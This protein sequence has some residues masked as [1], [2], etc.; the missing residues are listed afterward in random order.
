LGETRKAHSLSGT[1]ETIVVSPDGKVLAVW[2]GA[3]T[4]KYQAEIE[5]Y[6]QIHLRGLRDL[7]TPSAPIP[8]HSQSTK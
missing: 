6:F 8:A 3:W 4:G 5:T 1:P 7:N 2:L